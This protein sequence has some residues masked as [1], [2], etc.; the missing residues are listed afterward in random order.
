MRRYFWDT[1]IAL[2]IILPPLSSPGKGKETLTQ[3]EC[4]PLFGP[5]GFT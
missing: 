2:S 5:G 1:R 3:D 4:K